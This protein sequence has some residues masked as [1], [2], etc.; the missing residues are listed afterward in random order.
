MTLYGLSTSIVQRYHI[1]FL[2]TTIVST[3]WPLFPPRASIESIRSGKKLETKAAI[4][5]TLICGL[6]LRLPGMQQRAEIYARRGAAVLFINATAKLATMNPTTTTAVFTKAGRIYDE[7][8]WPAYFVRAPGTEEHVGRHIEISIEVNRGLRSVP[9][10]SAPN[11]CRVDLKDAIENNEQTLRTALSVSRTG[12]HRWKCRKVQG[13][14]IARFNVAYRQVY[15]LGNARNR[16]LWL[17]SLAKHVGRQIYHEGRMFKSWKFT[18][19]LLVL[20]VKNERL[21]CLLL[22]GY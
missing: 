16:C 3:Q 13:Q 14:T 18:W 10:C 8:H 6:S 19:A 17:H 22:F 15:S 2:S 9:Q 12:L 4:V 21:S 20:N 1:F 5:V 7:L 11:Y